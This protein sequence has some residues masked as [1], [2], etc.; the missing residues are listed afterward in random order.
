MKGITER[1]REV[2]S[3]IS[4][5]TKVNSYPPTVREI[6]FHFGVSIRAVQDYIAALI[7]KGY[8]TQIPGKA[9]TLTL[10]GKAA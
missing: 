9:R 1:Q 7:K 4:D 10:T 8:L 6:S 5:F 2:L 3:Y